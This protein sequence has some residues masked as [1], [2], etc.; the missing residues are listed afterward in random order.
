MCLVLQAI[1]WCM[2]KT[3]VATP[4][5]HIQAP[6]FP[7]TSMHVCDWESDRQKK[8]GGDFG[9]HRHAG[10]PF[11]TSNPKAPTQIK[12]MHTDLWISKMCAVHQCHYFQASTSLE[13]P[14]RHLPILIAKTPGRA[15]NWH[16]CVS[17]S[18]H[19]AQHNAI[20]K[21]AKST[22]GNAPSTPHTQKWNL[23]ESSPPCSHKNWHPKI[24]DP[25]SKTRHSRTYLQNIF[26]HQVQLSRAY[27]S[28]VLHISW[29]PCIPS[30]CCCTAS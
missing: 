7:A 23:C 26:S 2:C 17:Q 8:E 21:I 5:T 13:I 9:E 24:P 15:T 22:F 19:N 3:G 28:S 11:L 20:R 16:F 29:S 30:C 10:S 1:T 25:N 12:K 4:R 27:R 18:S 14:L 6:F